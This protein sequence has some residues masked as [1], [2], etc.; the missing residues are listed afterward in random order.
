M[1]RLIL[2]LLVIGF[3]SFTQVA[4]A[5]ETLESLEEAMGELVLVEME[6]SL[7]TIEIALYEDK[8]PITVKNFLTYTEEKFYDG[9][10][11]HRVISDF[12]IQGGGLTPDLKPKETQEPIRNEAQNNLKNK[13]GTIAMARTPVVDSATSQFFIN[14]K[15]NDFLDHKNATAAGFGY[16]VFGKVIS[17]M[18]V[19]DAINKVKTG[20]K[21]QIP[22]KNRNILQDVPVETIL[23]KSVKVQEETTQT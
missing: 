16:A 22:D 4:D 23:I 6:T 11:F 3:L 1:R 13:R 2:G 18:D 7:G 8:A 14:V 17:G 5:E 21:S 9:T 10:I 20:N 12:M 15:D 19:V